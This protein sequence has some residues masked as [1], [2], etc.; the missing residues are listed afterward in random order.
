[1]DEYMLIIIKMMDTYFKFCG[2]KMRGD[3]IL[4]NLINYSLLF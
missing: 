4:Y 3:N 2:N 1:M